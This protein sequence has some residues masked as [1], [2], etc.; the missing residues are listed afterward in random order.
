MNFDIKAK[1]EELVKK[2]SGDKS[3]LEK[4]T[5]DPIGAVKGLLGS[6]GLPADLPTDQPEGLVS[7][8]QSKLKLDEAGGVGGILGKIG[9]L[10]GGKK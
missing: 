3:L 9:G 7:G 2:I 1:I 4:F 10:F 8:V 5:K 6:V